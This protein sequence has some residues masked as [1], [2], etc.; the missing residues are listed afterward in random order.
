MK[1]LYSLLSVVSLLC[2]IAV[3]A[4]SGNPVTLRPTTELTSSAIR[5][6]DVFDGVPKELDRDIAISPYAG[7]SVTYDVRVLTRLAQQYRLD[8]QPQGYTDHTLLTRAAHYLTADMIQPIVMNKLQ[9]QNSDDD[10]SYEITFDNRNFSLALPAEHAPDFKLINFSYD[11]HTRRFR[12][13]IIAKVET[14]ALRQPLSGRVIISK[15]I[16]VLSRRLGVNSI[17][18]KNDL[19]LE[20]VEE[21]KINKSTLLSISNI[22]N[23]ELR[24]E[25]GIGSVLHSRDITAPRLVLR[26]KMVTMKIQT[27]VMLIT[28]QG[29]ALQDGTKGDVVRIKNLQS[30]RVV[31]AIVESD[32]VVNV[33]TGA[34]NQIA[35]L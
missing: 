28:A 30:N 3:P 16:P 32:G 23:K 33:Q 9:A 35:A 17:I 14:G 7:Q 31:E 11:K 19:R 8:W 15:R 34:S 29:R 20:W 4:S 24:Q 18:G 27:P 1:F 21:T 2:V 6:S 13:E 22:I 12:S 5:L 25:R 26:G 10:T